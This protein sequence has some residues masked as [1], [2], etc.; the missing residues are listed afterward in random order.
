M[1][2]VAAGL[3]SS[4]E[5]A[6]GR[7]L[8]PWWV[9]LITGVSWTIVGLVVLRFDYTSVHAVSLLFGCVAIA[10]GVMELVMTFIAPG[11]WKLLNGVLALAFLV[12]RGGA[13][14]HSRNTVVGAL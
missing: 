13:V 2:S 3:E 5:R 9:F 10:A 4:A 14:G 6:V 12:A 1:S 7:M 11:W 8:P